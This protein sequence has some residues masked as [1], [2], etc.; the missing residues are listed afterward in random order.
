[1]VIQLPPIKECTRCHTGQKASETGKVAMGFEDEENST[2]KE[3]QGNT[4][5]VSQC[6]PDW[7]AETEAAGP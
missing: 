5:A 1:M 3:A 6:K 7:F 4:K 2:G